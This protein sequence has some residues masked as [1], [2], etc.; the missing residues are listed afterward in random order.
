[1]SVAIVLEMEKGKKQIKDIRIAAGSV[2]P[3]P[4]RF[5]E[6]EDLLRGKSP[7]EENLQRASLKVSETMINRTGIRPSTSYKRPVMEAL[8]IRAMRKA[9]EG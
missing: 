1:M 5:S 9:I 8:F 4:R 7:S 3:T 6:A 2:T